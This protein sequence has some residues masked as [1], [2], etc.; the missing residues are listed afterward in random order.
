MFN[1]AYRV[2]LPFRNTFLYFLFLVWISIL[3]KLEKFC[4]F[5]PCGM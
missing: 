4:I 3:F 1:T 2:M 5:I